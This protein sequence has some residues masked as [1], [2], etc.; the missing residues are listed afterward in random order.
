MPRRGAAA[1]AALSCLVATAGPARA[2]VERRWV[3]M[4]TY[5]SVEV[6]AKDQARAEAAI[7]GI[8]TVFARV[9]AAMSNWSP[10][11]ELSALNR[12]AG[13]REY[14]VQDPDLYRCIALALDFARLTDG[15]FDP[16]VGPLMRV[17]GFRPRVARDPSAAETAEA[18]RHVGF[19][20]VILDRAARSVR[21]TDPAV[22]LDLGGIAKGLALD[23]VLPV[24]ARSDCQA[25]LIDLGGELYAWRSPPG[26][27]GFTIGVRD[28][29]EGSAI[30][31]ALTIENRAVSTS[32]N[33]E[34]SLEE[35]GRT[36]GHLMDPTTGQPAESAVLAA[37]VFAD[38][39]ADADA[40][41]TALLVA[42]PSRAPAILARSPGAEAVLVV[43]EE[44]GVVLLASASLA[45]RFRVEP[46]FLARSGGQVRYTLPPA[47]PG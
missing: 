15:A 24:L 40:L 5:A 16:T 11:S 47:P 28:P 38:R 46:G 13:R 21:F 2:S 7:E 17:H 18:A 32:G 30:V 43:R 6:Y 26:A 4:G 23:L 14:P 20:R 19:W 34:N 9:D 41:S 37:T 3:V 39:G 22:E 35:G 45:G 25:A 12:E 8:R 36:I 10:A 44:R 42:G 33:Y 27:A 29:L 1:L 31:G